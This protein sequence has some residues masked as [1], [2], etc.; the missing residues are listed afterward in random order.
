MKIIANYYLKKYTLDIEPSNTILDIK[1][2]LDLGNYIII[3][4]F[5]RI[6]KNNETA[7][8]IGLEEGSLIYCKRWI[9][10]LCHF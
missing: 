6:K 3:K 10:F 4:Y 7:E 9:Y 1:N 2:K 5:G 8:D